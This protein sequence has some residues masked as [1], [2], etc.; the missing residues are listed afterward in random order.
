MVHNNS[1]PARLL[2]NQVGQ[3]KAWLGLRLVGFGGRDMLG[4]HV[5]LLSP[6]TPQI[7]RVRTEGSYASANDPRVLFGLGEATGS[8]KVRVTW[9]DGTVETWDGLPTGAYTTLRQGEGS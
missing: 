3:E 7:R 1:G 9:P 4:T 6:G 8:A 2:I 5:E